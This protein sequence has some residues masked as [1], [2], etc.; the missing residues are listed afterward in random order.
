MSS[1]SSHNPTPEGPSDRKPN[2]PL[3]SSLDRCH[4]SEIVREVEHQNDTPLRT[5]DERVG[6]FDECAFPLVR[7]VCHGAEVQAVGQSPDQRG[8]QTHMSPVRTAELHQLCLLDLLIPGGEV[9]GSGLVKAVPAPYDSSIQLLDFSELVATVGRLDSFASG[10]T[11]G[12]AFT[13]GRDI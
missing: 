13:V 4:G 11:G 1:F 9:P 6:S 2:G 7:D 3:G 8:S 12:G 5:R 10:A